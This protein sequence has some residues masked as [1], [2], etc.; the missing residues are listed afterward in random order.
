MMIPKE[1]LVRTVFFCAPTTQCSDFSACGGGTQHSRPHGSPLTAASSVK[2]AAAVTRTILWSTEICSKA[3]VT[4]FKFVPEIFLC[5]RCDPRCAA[6]G[7]CT[8]NLQPFLPD[9]VNCALSL[10]WEMG[11]MYCS[12]TLITVTLSYCT[13]PALLAW[14]T[15]LPAPQNFQFWCHQVLPFS[16]QSVMQPYCLNAAH[17]SLLAAMKTY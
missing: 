12:F 4:S 9:I 13:N 15:I 1:Y 11:Q 17:I 8:D 16:L 2:A 10:P 7:C 6:A 5:K 14:N 3:V